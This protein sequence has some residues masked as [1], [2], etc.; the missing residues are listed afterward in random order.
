M[1]ITFVASHT[2]K[3]ELMEYYKIIKAILEKSEIKLKY[4]GLFN[5]TD[6]IDKSEASRNLWYKKSMNDIK[7]SDIVVVEISYPST[8]NVGH[9]LTYALE[10][11]KPVVALY[12]NDRDPLFLRGQK[13]DKLTIIPYSDSKDLEKILNSALEYAAEQMDTRFNFFISPK[14]GN[15]LDWVA[16]KL[17]MPRAVYLRKLIEKDMEKNKGY[18]G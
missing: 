5:A 16:K 7:E 17:K 9:C 18:T 10:I 11:G 3:K 15:Y 2:Q 8:A 1:K 13:N 4:G 14:I 12:K 6:D